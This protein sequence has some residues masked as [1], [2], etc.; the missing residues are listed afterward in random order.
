MNRIVFQLGS[1]VAP[2]GEPFL[3]ISL[4]EPPVFGSRAM[5]FTCQAGDPAFAALKAAV[6]AEDSIKLAGGKLFAAVWAH[7][8]AQQ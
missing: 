5:P 6:L 4:E 1:S 3:S 8:D 7:P 2:N